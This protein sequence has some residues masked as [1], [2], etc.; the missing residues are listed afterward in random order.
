MPTTPEQ[1]TP[2]RIAVARASFDAAK[3]AYRAEQ[4]RIANRLPQPGLPGNGGFA[5]RHTTGEFVSWGSA[6]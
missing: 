3:A 1:M 5:Y 4:K 2:E 6:A